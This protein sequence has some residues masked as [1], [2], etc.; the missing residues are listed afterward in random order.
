MSRTCLLL[1]S[2][3]LAV[4]FA[5]AAPPEVLTVKGAALVPVRTVAQWLGATLKYDA[6]T[7]VTT[8]TLGKKSAGVTVNSTTATV[9]GKKV[10]LS[11]APVEH[12][13]TTYV[14]LRLF[15]DA[16]GVKTA[17]DAKK[18]AATVTHPANGKVLTLTATTKKAADPMQFF[19]VIASGDAATV[20]TMLAANPELLTAP[21]PN[22]ES[23]IFVA[24][25]TGQL[26]ILKDLEAKGASLKAKLPAMA[27][28]DSLMAGANLL[29]AAVMGGKT[30]LVEYLVGKGLD[31]NSTTALGFTPLLMAAGDGN[32]EMVEYLL[33]HGA[34]AK[35]R[36]VPPAAALADPKTKEMSEK[37]GF[38]TAL[39][40][41]FGH[42]DVEALLTKSGAP[43]LDPSLVKEL[44]AARD[45]AK[46]AAS[47]NAMRQ[48]A[49][50]A[51]MYARDHDEKFPTAD[52][53]W[54]ELNLNTRQLQDPAL[55]TQL[56]GFG[57]NKALSGLAMSDIKA[58]EKT[59][60]LADAK[61][62]IISSPDDLDRTRHGDGFFVIYCDGNTE[63]LKSDAVVS[64]APP[65]PDPAPKTTEAPKSTEPPLATK[66]AVIQTAKG[67]I[68]VELYGKDAPGTVDNFV[69]LAEK[70]FYKDLTFHRV[71]TDPAFNLIQGGDPKGDGTGGPGYSIK[72]E[73]SPKLRHVKGAIAMA[74]SAEPDSAGCQF[75]IC[76]VDIPQLDDQYAVFGKVVSGLDIAAKIV[77]GDK[78]KD[79]VIK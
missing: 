38:G 53:F 56:I 18:Q 1:L 25:A 4:S 66:H 35:A 34:D 32:K 59:I 41:A 21:G 61:T 26:E 16:F 31:I 9:N 29:H 37:A 79:I 74:R 30:A 17:W 51:V 69:K 42:A 45:Q 67:D 36:I 54:N 27:D 24:A 49:M 78:I 20:K 5:L 6:K 62:P 63:F 68:E 39:M 77:K 7:K 19:R 8:L 50:A 28:G 57:F 64:L 12:E 72:R 47:T 75:Y 14:P 46:K 76:L 15:T 65:P 55:P 43:A 3:L 48:I 2:A 10:T 40:F 44:S 11:A 23:P 71:E 60:L 33:A 52:K 13:K 58:P 73:I 22:G 70:H